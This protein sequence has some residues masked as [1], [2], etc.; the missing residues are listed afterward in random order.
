[1]KYL[2]ALLDMKWQSME[3]L[4]KIFIGFSILFGN[5]FFRFWILF[6]IVIFK[7]GK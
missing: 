1:M 2:I 5:Y 7:T 6:Y 4:I 3:L